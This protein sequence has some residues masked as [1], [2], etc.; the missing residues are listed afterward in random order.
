MWLKSVSTMGPCLTL[1]II[2][3]I[4]LIFLFLLCSLSSTD[5][6]LNASFVHSYWLFWNM[7]V[8]Q[9]FSQNVLWFILCFYLVY[10]WKCLGSVHNHI[11]YVQVFLQAVT[12]AAHSF[13]VS[14]IM[15]A[16]MESYVIAFWVQ[17]RFV[18]YWDRTTVKF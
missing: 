10:C 18:F 11:C 5:L 12:N 7:F 8:N 6:Y 4:F 16:H 9:W 17:Y 1:W 2:Y 3:N 13:A 14:Q 15:A